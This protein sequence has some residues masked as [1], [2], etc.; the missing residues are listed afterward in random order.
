[1][2]LLQTDKET[3]N[4]KRQ[5]SSR[6]PINI[7]KLEYSVFYSLSFRTFLETEISVLISILLVKIATVFLIETWCKYF[8]LFIW[9]SGAL[10]VPLVRKFRNKIF[11]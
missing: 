4:K 11:F 6:T 8:W 3:G 10:C 9:R 1:M 7:S 5:K 2:V